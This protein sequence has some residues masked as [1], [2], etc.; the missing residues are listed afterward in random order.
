MNERKDRVSK[1]GKI[2]N[3]T[4]LFLAR[5]FHFDRVN[6]DC[7]AF[8]LHLWTTNDAWTIGFSSILV[9]CF[10]VFSLIRGLK[11]FYSDS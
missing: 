2:G 8:K 9:S 6:F 5:V 4:R 7:H 3:R 11:V 10:F 1:L